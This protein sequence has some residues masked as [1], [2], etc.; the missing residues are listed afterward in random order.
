MRENAIYRVTPPDMLLPDSGPIITV[1]S[2]KP[3]FIDEVEAL[4][5]NIFKSVS[6]TIYHPTGKINE[7]NMAWVLS[8]IRFSDTVYVDLDDINELG[9]AVTLINDDK[10]VYINEYN[11]KKGIVK[12]LNSTNRRIFD[13]LEEYSEMVIQGFELDA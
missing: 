7:S 13:S 9:I 1:I 5:E 12:L 11:K 8:M 10:V 2:S 4:Y 3:D 6:V